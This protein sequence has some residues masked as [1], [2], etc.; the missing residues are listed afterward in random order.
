[1]EELA[2]ILKKV[3]V[4]LDIPKV[5]LQQRAHMTYEIG[6]KIPYQRRDDVIDRY[7]GGPTA[8]RCWFCVS[9]SKGEILVVNEI[10]LPLMIVPIAQRE[11]QVRKYILADPNFF[12]QIISDLKED[13]KRISGQELIKKLLLLHMEGKLKNPFPIQRKYCS[14]KRSSSI[15]QNWK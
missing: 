5:M 3:I 4:D 15:N 13:V 1:M 8:W 10:D 6:Q 7:Y 14:P 12:I 11:Q 2:A 9:L